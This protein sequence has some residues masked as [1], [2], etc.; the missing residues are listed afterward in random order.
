M[1]NDY[2]MADRGFLTAKSFGDLRDLIG[3]RFAEG[4]VV[5]VGPDDPLN[6]A[7]T[8]MR[9]YDVSQLPVLE[10]SKIV[11]ILDES[12]LLLAAVAD[13][14]VF[15]QPV[16]AFMTSRLQTVVPRATIEELLPIFDVGH[17]AIVVDGEEF[18]GL[19]Y[20]SR[21]RQPF[22]AAACGVDFELPVREMAVG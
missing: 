11:G 18:C 17:V 4:A 8:R 22:A 15:Q 16:K 6:I 19:D 5:G 13:A 14:G 7:Y 3:H 20:A 21:R 12:D 1:F 10:G 2:W 9:L